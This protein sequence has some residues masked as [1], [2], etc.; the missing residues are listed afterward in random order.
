MDN[1]EKLKN[2]PKDPRF[3]IEVQNPK[4]EELIKTY[5]EEKTADN[6]NKLIYEIRRSRFLVPASVS[7]DKKPMPLFIKN[8]AGEA[9]LPIYTSKNELPKD[10]PSPAIINMPYQALNNLVANENAKLDGLVFNPYSQNLIFKKPLVEKIELAEKAAKEG[11]QTKTIKMTEPQY[12]VFERI[13]F[14]HIFL[15]TKLY[16]GGADFIKRLADEKE[17]FID[18]LYEEAFQQKQMYLFMEED[19]SVMSL[20][21]SDELN[22]TRVD[23]PTRNMAPG[24]SVR[25]Y[26]V[27]NLTKN[28]GRYF[29]IDTTK[30]QVTQLTEVTNEL[31]KIS[32][33]PAPV[34]GAELQTILDM[35]GGESEITS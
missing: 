4:V 5:S 10:Q 7:K 26:L 23:F 27:W 34:E 11:K 15:P 32:H 3:T 29:V 20:Q 9:Y 2:L 28:E 18:S 16:T 35:L 25:A 13:R 24:C 12:I 6:L 8:N 31:K 33:G 14:E 21:I 17:A 1:N 30:E 22:V 19:F